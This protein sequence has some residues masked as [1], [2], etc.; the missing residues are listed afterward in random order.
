MVGRCNK[1]WTGNQRIRSSASDSWEPKRPRNTKLIDLRH[2]IPR[3]LESRTL[4]DTGRS[5]SCSRSESRK[6]V[7][8]LS[9]LQR[10]F[11]YTA[12][13]SQASRLN[14]QYQDPA[15]LII[16]KSDQQKGFWLPE[17]GGFLVAIDFT[18]L[19][20]LKFSSQVGVGFTLNISMVRGIRNESLA[21][22]M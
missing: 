13:C 19:T 21:P 15:I 22:V 10:N 2:F 14:G 6:V 20:V 12:I 7:S 5:N 11:T 16:Y 3:G 4:S 8:A 17:R 9:P 18:I 1:H